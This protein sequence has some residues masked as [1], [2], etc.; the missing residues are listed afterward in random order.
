MSSINN[1]DNGLN[2]TFNFKL[3]PKVPLPSIGNTVITGATGPTGIKGET[4]Y[5]E[6]RGYTG[7]TG[8]TGATGDIGQTGTYSTDAS[9]NYII[10]NDIIPIIPSSDLG[11]SNSYFGIDDSKLARSR[12]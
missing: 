1:N 7:P 4:F 12:R 9:G 3:F 10:S 2:G 11:A 5:N 8:Y 6:G